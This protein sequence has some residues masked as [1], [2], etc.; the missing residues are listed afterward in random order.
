MY[1]GKQA[2][3]VVQ[4][5]RFVCWFSGTGLSSVWEETGCGTFLMSDSVCGGFELTTGTCASAIRIGFNLINP[6]DEDGSMFIGVQRRTSCHANARSDFGVA[7]ACSFS[8]Q[9]TV[10]LNGNGSTKMRVISEECGSQCVSCSCVCVDSCWHTFQIEGRA[11][12]IQHYIDGNVEV[13]HSTNIPTLP[14]SPNILST[15]V[16][17]GQN[18]VTSIR[19]FEAYNT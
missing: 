19:Y 15:Q 4:K 11:C 8:S 6:Y 3:C 17:S 5:Q 16:G 10:W 12:D 1:D 18:I 2:L 9:F 14:L 13:T 7:N